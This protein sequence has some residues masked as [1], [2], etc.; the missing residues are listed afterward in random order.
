MKNLDHQ[1]ATLVEHLLDSGVIALQYCCSESEE[2]GDI[3]HYQLLQPGQMGDNDCLN[4]GE[5][6]VISKTGKKIL[7]EYIDGKYIKLY[8]KSYLPVWFEPPL[9][10]S[11]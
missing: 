2:K 10:S 11:N 1:V 6:P 9:S 3:E 4:S 7:E 5:I 8:P